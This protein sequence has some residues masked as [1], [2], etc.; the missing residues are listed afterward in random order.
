MKQIY[1]AI[2]TILLFIFSSC[3]S[4]EDFLN[5]DLNELEITQTDSITL[6]KELVYSMGFDSTMIVC[7][8]EYIIVEED[9]LIPK[10]ELLKNEVKARQL[11]TNK[12]VKNG[13][14]IYVGVDNTISKSS[15]W[16]EAIKRVLSIYNEYTGLNF[17]YSENNPTI[18]I[19]KTRINGS[20]VCAEG[21]FPTSETKPGNKI[22]INNSFFADIDN[23]LSFDEKVFLIM[24]EMGH[25]LGLR[26]TDAIIRNEGAGKYGLVQIPGTPEIDSNSFMNSRTCGFQWTNMP[27]FDEIALRELWP[28]YYKLSFYGSTN[29]HTFRKGD[30]IQINWKDIPSSM[31]ANKTF[32]GWYYDAG[33]NYECKYGTYIKYSGTLYP[34]WRDYGKGVYL[35]KF[36][37]DRPAETTYMVLERDAIVTAKVTVSKG[38]NEWLDISR[39]TN[40]TGAAIS[41]YGQ[42]PNITVPLWMD[43]FMLGPNVPTDPI[44]TKTWKVYLPAGKYIYGAYFASGLGSQN[45]SPSEKHGRTTVEISY[46]H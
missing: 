25:N 9:I 33:L 17:I 14:L 45:N 30:S 7:S 4:N 42:K 39:Y 3:N 34:K 41:N 8:D 24:H 5:K 20:D 37:I 27:R 31:P 46:N 38:L 16:I 13:S 6:I 12:Y 15:N 19:T 29:Q 40:Q 10:Q 32:A 26:H 43:G 28:I 21:V 36:S 1:L 35:T 2:F 44:I 22:M 23:Y 18:T 11:R